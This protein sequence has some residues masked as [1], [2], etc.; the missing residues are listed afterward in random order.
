MI[1]K[2]PR[3]GYIAGVTIISNKSLSP[4]NLQMINPDLS[5]LKPGGML[6]ACNLPPSFVYNGL[7]QI[8]MSDADIQFQVKQF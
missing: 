2:I 4:G 7:R 5:T 3:D 8:C 6:M 1:Q